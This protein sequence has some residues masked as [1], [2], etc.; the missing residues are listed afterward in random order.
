MSIQTEK[1]SE[2]DFIKKLNETRER[3]QELFENATKVRI[4]KKIRNCQHNFVAETETER[5][6]SRNIIFCKE[7]FLTLHPEDDDTLL[8]RRLM[9][10]Q[11]KE[12]LKR[13]TSEPYCLY[14]MCRYPLLRP[15]SAVEGNYRH[16]PVD[17]RL[18]HDKWQTPLFG[19]DKTAS[20]KIE[21]IDV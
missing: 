17:Y 7:C 2:S 9:T 13:L 16:P 11:P 3:Y 6:M 14:V 15:L 12:S 10:D 21:W 20:S 1:L 19:D 5:E 4:L 18:Y 8:Y